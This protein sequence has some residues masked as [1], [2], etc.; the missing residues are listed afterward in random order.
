MPEMSTYYIYR[1]DICENDLYHGAYI[2]QHKIGSKDPSCDGYKGSGCRWKREILSNH[3]PVTKTILR[4]CDDVREANFWEEFYIDQAKQS[5]EYLWNV[6]K[7]GGGYDHDKKYTEEELRLHNKER[8]NRWYESNQEHITEYRKQYFEKN[9]EAIM[10]NHREYNGKN[11][12]AVIEYYRQ[13]YRKN[14]ERL[15]EK[16]KQYYEEHKDHLKQKMREYGKQYSIINAEKLAAKAKDY[17]DSH[18]EEHRQYWSRQCCYN[19]E[20]LT[21]N[22]LSS[23]LRRK[24]IPNPMQ[25]AKQYLIT[26]ENEL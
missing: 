7:G 25:V 20:T 4:L 5:G 10:A 19:G 16:N 23:R 17:N 11:K 6:A 26:K 2:G 14:K 21:I 22:A 24:Q 12:E 1:M 9:K 8:F 15:D 18:K 13:Y 3:I